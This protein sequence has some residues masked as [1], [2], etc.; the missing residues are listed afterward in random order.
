MTKS[1]QG[2]TFILLNRSYN[3]VTQTINIQN[4]PYSALYWGSFTTGQQWVFGVRSCRGAS[5]LSS[6]S[7][8]S[9]KQRRLHARLCSC[10]LLPH[11]PA[12][13][14]LPLIVPL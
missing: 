7:D 5:A 1:Y 6:A 10:A 9:S 4:S 2:I 12:C 8:C 3:A 13:Q 14:G 11:Q